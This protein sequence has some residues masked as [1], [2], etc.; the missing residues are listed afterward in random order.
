MKALAFLPMEVYDIGRATPVPNMAA[1]AL[2]FK[3]LRVTLVR[4][5]PTNFGWNEEVFLLS[6]IA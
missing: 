4:E 1:N 3:T 2:S 5:L 6:Q